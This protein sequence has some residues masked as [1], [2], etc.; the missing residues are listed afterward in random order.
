MEEEIDSLEEMKRKILVVSHCFF[1]DGTKLKYENIEDAK[2]ERE[3]KRNFLRKMLDEGV[4]LIQLPCPE[5]LLYG[6]NR[7]G[8]VASQFDT[9]FYKEASKKLLEPILLQLREYQKNEDRFELLGVVGIDGS[10]SC[11]IQ[12]TY[13]GNWGGEFSGNPNFEQTMAS[14]KKI[15]KPGIFMEV[16]MNELKNANV[17]IGFHTM[18]SILKTIGG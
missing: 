13:D 16:F 12:Y 14:I 6:A 2:K 9:P 18:D 7:W 15:E 8:H 5:F 4:E 11:G 17:E 10:P 3:Q 1:N